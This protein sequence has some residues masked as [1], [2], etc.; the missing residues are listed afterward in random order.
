MSP[1]F[2]SGSQQWKFK[3]YVQGDVLLDRVEQRHQG[4][5]DFTYEMYSA[6]SKAAAMRFL[7]RIP[8]SQIPRQYYVVVETPEG[9]F[10][11]DV[12]GVYEEQ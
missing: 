7:E 4:P 5:H 12:D 9:N 1:S 10:G 2:T 8:T 11:K 6:D 3:Q